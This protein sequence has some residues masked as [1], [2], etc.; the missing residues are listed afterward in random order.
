[1]VDFSGGGY[2]GCGNVDFKEKKEYILL[3]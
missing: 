2:K 3:D 1:M